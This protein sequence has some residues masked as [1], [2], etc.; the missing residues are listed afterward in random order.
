MNPSPP[1]T[2]D[3]VAVGGLAALGVLGVL[4]VLLWILLSILTGYKE[5]K[6]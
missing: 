3:T 5:P 1:T 6:L 4:G 2:H